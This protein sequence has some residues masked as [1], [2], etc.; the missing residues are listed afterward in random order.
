MRL[1]NDNINEDSE[2]AIA[3]FSKWILK[4]GDGKVPTIKLEQ[5]E[6]EPVW[7]K[8]L[9]DLLIKTDKDHIQ[10]I[11]LEVYSNFEENFANAAYPKK[12]LLLHLQMR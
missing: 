12:G 9:N 7:I 4:V 3:N 5:D 11:T 10:N 8:I 2:K 6:K 1:L